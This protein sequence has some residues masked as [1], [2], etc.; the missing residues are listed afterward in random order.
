MSQPEGEGVQSGATD[1]TQSGTVEPTTGTGSTDPKPNTDGTQSG[2]SEAEK[3]AETY[4]A[5]MQAAD[6]RAAKFEEELRSIRD[7]DLPEAEKLKRDYAE[8]QEKLA[9]LTEKTN[10]Q[11][12]ENA[13][14]KDS[15]HDW[16][17]P[18]AALKLVDLDKVVV[19]EDG[20]VSGLKDALKALANAHPYL[21]KQSVEPKTPEPGATAPGNNGGTGGQRQNAK[22]MAARIPALQTRVKRS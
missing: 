3:L 14:L 17:N 15:T 11:S 5:R 20:S 19:N 9:A 21:V 12:L 10:R 7:K 8:A 22:T 6:Q 2:P 1:G 16:H 13:F 4:R 18:E